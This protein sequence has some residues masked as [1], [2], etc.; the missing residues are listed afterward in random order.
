[1]KTRTLKQLLLYNYRYIFAYSTIVILGLF[2]LLWQLDTL[3]PGLSQTELSVAARHAHVN[4]ILHLPI[5]PLHS[6]L[7][8]VSIHLLPINNWSLRLPSV[9]LAGA[10]VVLLYLLLKKWFG[11]PT[12]LISSVLFI[13][14]DW[15]L[16]IARLGTGS[17]E[18]SFW[19][20]FA[21]YS[22]TKVL[23]HKTI[24]LIPFT[25]SLIGLLFTPFGPYACIVLIASMIGFKVFRERIIEATRFTKISSVSLLVLAM[26]VLAVVTWN[27]NQFI[28]SIFALQDLPNIKQYLSNLLINASAAVAI[29]PGNNSL[30]GPHRVFSIRFF[31]LIFALFGL[32]MLWKTKINKLNLVVLLLAVVLTLVGGLGF[33]AQGGSLMLIPV[34]IFVTAGIRHLM[35]RWRRTFP[36]NPYARIIA[37]LPLGVLFV[38]V[39]LQHYQ[40]YFLLWPSQTTTYETFTPDFALL[41]TELNYTKNAQKTCNVMTT[42]SDLEMLL[43]ASKPKCT[44][45]FINTPPAKLT[46]RLIVPASFNVQAYIQTGHVTHPLVSPTKAN[47][48]RWTVIEPLGQ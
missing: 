43:I 6:C 31:E 7:Q 5:Y 17:I 47:S 40:S 13:S 34:A 28:K 3:P 1:M 37:Y 29:L 21:L 4:S 27:N 26:A 44:P 15:F 41:Q 36:K 35:H 9:L 19:L 42:D 30:V 33:D 2:F 12:A 22:F 48:L 45:T 46:T 32:A 38:C 23:V 39:V 20:A 8:W 25:L 11:K 24:W 18:F 14:A 10:T 16:F